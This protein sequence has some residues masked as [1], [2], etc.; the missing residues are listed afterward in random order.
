MHKRP[1]SSHLRS[2]RKVDSEM[3]MKWCFK[4]IYGETGLKGSKPH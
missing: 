2:K 3:G 1:G 4:D